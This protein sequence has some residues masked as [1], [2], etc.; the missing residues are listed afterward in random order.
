MYKKDSS[1]NSIN[2]NRHDCFD[3]RE[4]YFSILFNTK[5]SS[6]YV[7]FLHFGNRDKLLAEIKLSG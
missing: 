3:E 5:Y 1:E 7:R 4:H 6:K 2:Q